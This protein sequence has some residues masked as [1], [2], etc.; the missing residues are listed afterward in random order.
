MTAS[1]GFA[2]GLLKLT[3]RLLASVPGGLSALPCSRLPPTDLVAD[4][5]DSV[6]H[7]AVVVP[8]AEEPTPLAA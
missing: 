5:R 2:C 3:A 6:G 4:G 8:E 1:D 7:D